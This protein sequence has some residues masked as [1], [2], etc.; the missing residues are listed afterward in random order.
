MYL[1]PEI[2][3]KTARSGGKGG[4]HVNKVETM[5]EG[6]WNIEKS[7]L[8]TDEQK[9]LI[10]SKLENKINADGNL[11]VKNQTE[12][13]QLGN[14]EKVVEK[15]NRLVI[16]ALVVPKKRKATR[17]TKG[18]VENRIESKKKTGEIKANR[19]KIKL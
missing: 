15:M 5:V 7:A 16:K 12:R 18:S 6:Y 1:K 10:Q 11:F 2:R 9:Q 3:F 8:F 17:P 19:K 4:Q 14:K 13:T